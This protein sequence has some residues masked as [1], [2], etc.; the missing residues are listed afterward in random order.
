[1]R[2]KEQGV[3]C[4]S[5][6]CGSTRSGG[7]TRPAHHERGGADEWLGGGCPEEAGWKPAPTSGR[8]ADGRG[9]GALRAGGAGRMWALSGAAAV[10]GSLHNPRLVARKTLTPTLSQRAREQE[11]PRFGERG[12]FARVRCE[13]LS[14]LAG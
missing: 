13:G 5:R 11:R 10:R 9:L 2:G 3:G 8:D 14:W 12:A 4:C 6:G 1:M 7:Y